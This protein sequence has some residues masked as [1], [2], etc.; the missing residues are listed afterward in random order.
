MAGSGQ[1]MDKEKSGGQRID[2][3]SF[4]AGGVDKEVIMPRG[5]HLKAQV[6]ADGCGE[7]MSYEDTSEKIRAQ[8]EAGVRKEKSHMPK[9]LYRN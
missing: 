9:P 3:H 5:A 6:D 4:W 1:R 2:D 8:Q 7:L